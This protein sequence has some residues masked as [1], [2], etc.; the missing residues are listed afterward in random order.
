MNVLL[1]STGFTSCI[2]ILIIFLAKIQRNSFLETYSYFLY[3]FSFISFYYSY[4]TLLQN[5]E[6]G[7]DK[8]TLSLTAITVI[9]F[10]GLIIF[11]IIKSGMRVPL[12]GIFLFLYGLYLV[13]CLIRK[14]SIL[15]LQALA[16]SPFIPANIVVWC[17]ILIL[18]ILSTVNL[19]PL[20]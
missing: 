12:V 16:W 13:Y 2:V 1:Y 11:E 20:F 15:S 14:K 8:V 9:S 4:A 19:S 17:V 5:K 6:K 10:V 18:L 3:I 7:S